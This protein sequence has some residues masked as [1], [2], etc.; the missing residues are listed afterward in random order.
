MGKDTINIYL[1]KD[2]RKQIDI[3]KQKYQLSLTTIIDILCF[4]TFRIFLH[5]GQLKLDELTKSY[6]Y[7]HKCKTS[8]KTPKT[9]KTINNGQGENHYWI[10]I[11]KSR[12]T[13][14]VIKIYLYKDIKKYIESDVGI[15]EYWNS[16]N[17]KFTTTKDEWWAY[18][19]HIRYERRSLK[20]NRE[21]YQ[22]ELD[23]MK[24]GKS[25]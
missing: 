13:T 8:I 19:Q 14:N 7:E 9:F 3:L 1:N 5:Y 24:N 12:F 11:K 10:A 20:E 6:L 17:K 23:K 25:N 4:E 18:N 2:E 15:Q 22:A 16:I 21:Y